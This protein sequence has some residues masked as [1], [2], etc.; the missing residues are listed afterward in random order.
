VTARQTDWS[1]GPGTEGPVLDWEARSA[2]D[3]R[4]MGPWVPV[5]PGPGCPGLLS[6]A[7]YL[8]YRVLLDSASDVI[9]PTVDEIRFSWEPRVLPAPRR[10]AGRVTP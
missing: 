9:S 6:G 4:Q 2:H 10:G 7:R 8:Q 5:A 1:D 3:P